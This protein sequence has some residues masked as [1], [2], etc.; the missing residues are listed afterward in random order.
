MLN[1]LAVK[2]WSSSL[3]ALEES[4]L[5]KNTFQA[6]S[7]GAVNWRGLKGVLVR[8]MRTRERSH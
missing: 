1:A 8:A 3:L 2:V 6:R 7:L 4:R 5:R